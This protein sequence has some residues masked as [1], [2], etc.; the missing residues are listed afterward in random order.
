MKLELFAMIVV[1]LGVNLTEA[2]PAETN[3][4]PKTVEGV[5]RPWE[6]VGRPEGLENRQNVV[7]C[8]AHCIDC[9]CQDAKGRCSNCN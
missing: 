6:P 5:E 1:L 7:Y 8:T 4:V 9:D 3:N 2:K